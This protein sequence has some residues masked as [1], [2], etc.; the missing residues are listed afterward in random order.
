M[1]VVLDSSVIVKW[2]KQEQDSDKALEL[3]EAYLN[4]DLEI[5]VPD[6]VFYEISN[7]MTYDDSFDAENVKE[8]IETLRDMEFDVVAPHTDLLNKA[9]EV[10]D[11]KDVTIYDAS[12]MALAEPLDAEMITTDQELVRK[13]GEGIDIQDLSPFVES[14]D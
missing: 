12:F 5:A 10:A 7:V 6:L 2:F 14:L 3:R 13:S 11:Q 4:T 8:S 9:I 1:G